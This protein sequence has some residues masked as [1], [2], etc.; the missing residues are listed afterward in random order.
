MQLGSSYNMGDYQAVSSCGQ[1]R[2]CCQA[3]TLNATYCC[4]EADTFPLDNVNEKV[5]H[6]PLP[7]IS[8]TS[9][10]V[11]SGP[12]SATTSATSASVPAAT[13]AASPKVQTVALGVGLGISFVIALTACVSLFYLRYHRNSTKRVEQ[14]NETPKTYSPCV[15]VSGYQEFELSAVKNIAAEMPVEK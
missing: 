13:N 11:I 15:E 7:S 8:Q 9:S 4:I 14:T 12:N 6:I 2:W 10:S 5:I 1:H 3:E